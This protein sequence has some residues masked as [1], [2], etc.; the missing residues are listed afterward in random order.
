MT[1]PPGPWMSGSLVTSTATFYN[2]DGVQADPE[3]V[4]L[5]YKTGAGT[6]NTA[7]YPAAPVTRLGEGVYQAELD[8]TGFHGP[9]Q[10]LWATQWA[11]TG[12]VQAVAVAYFS[13]VPAAL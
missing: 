5:K 6:T 9:G 3:V 7:V 1:T 4:T 12:D 8:T 10:Q 13:V 2:A 11:G